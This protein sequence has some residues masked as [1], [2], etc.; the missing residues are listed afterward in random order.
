M[1]QASIN[2]TIITKVAFLLF[3]L[4]SIHLM[5]AQEKQEEKSYIEFN[6][7]RNVVH[8]VYLGF[9][10]FFGQINNRNTYLGG[11]KLAYVANRKFEI[12]FTGVG[13]FSDQNIPSI[14]P[15][16]KDGL[17][18]GYGGLHLEPIFFGQ[19]TINLSFPILIGSG[20]VAYIEDYETFEEEIDGE[21]P[22]WDIAFVFE[23]GISVLYNI[24]RY[25]QF[26]I[27][28]KYRLSSKIIMSPKTV[29]NL[30]GFS[31]G[32]GIKIGVFNLGRNRYKKSLK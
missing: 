32:M 20:A 31:A 16:N 27:G 30:N 22:D 6:D 10:G 2:H 1:T 15:T 4:T 14:S 26:E 24:S 25:V 13:F 9:T 5:N 12:G 18:G 23:P 29:D 3:L 11:V 7:R 21:V 28:A 8:G 19:K 17:V